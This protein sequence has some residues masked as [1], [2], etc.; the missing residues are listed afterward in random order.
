MTLTVMPRG[1]KSRAR[2]RVSPARAAFV[3][4]VDRRAGET[5]AVCVDAAGANDASAFTQM[6]NCRL[7]G[8]EH[9]AHVDGDHPVEIGKGVVV[10]HT[11]RQDPGIVDEDVQPAQF[12]DCLRH[13]LPHRLRLCTVSLDGDGAAAGSLHFLDKRLSLVGRSGIGE[14]DGSAVI[15][16]T[17]DDRGA[18]SARSTRY[19]GGFSSERMRH[20][21]DFLIDYLVHNWT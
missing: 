6:R 8:D 1:A 20:D 10:D 11:E 4:A 16:K 9:R 19:E 13:G 3:I 21:L 18:D 15:G 7:D 5:G 14:G 12:L 2:P 17:P